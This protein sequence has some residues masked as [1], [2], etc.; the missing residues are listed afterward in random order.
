MQRFCYAV[1][2]VASPD[3]GFVVTCRD[4]PEVVTQGETRANALAE[5]EGALQAA[6]EMRIQDALP[7]PPASSLEAGEDWVAVPIVTSMNTALH[8]TM[9][10]QGL[11]KTGLLGRLG[12]DVQEARR[13]LNA[14]D[15][16]QIPA[17][18]AAL[19]SLGKRPE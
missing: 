3:G 15:Q 9:R 2:F 4:L 1:Q 8:L 14:A 11:S 12:T 19:H 6:I 17:L 13:I 16:G 5:A 10:D 7:I 18:E